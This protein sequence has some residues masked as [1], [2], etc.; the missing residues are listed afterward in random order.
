MQDVYEVVKGLLTASEGKDDI[1]LILSRLFGSSELMAAAALAEK[2][3]IDER[4]IDDHHEIDLQVSTPLLGEVS[5]THFNLPVP[6]CDCSDFN[7]NVLTGKKL[8]C[9]HMLAFLLK[10]DIH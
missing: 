3:H 8:L 1:L 4:Y 2:V 5:R 7:R 6:Y 10:R 9:V